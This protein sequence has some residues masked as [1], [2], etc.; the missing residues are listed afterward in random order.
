MLLSS[1]DL[2]TILTTFALALALTPIVRVAARRWG[3]VAQPKADRWHKKPTAML[4]GVAIFAPVVLGYF[5]LVPHTTQSVVVVTASAFMFALGLI[6]DLYHIKPYQKLIGQVMGAALVI[7]YGLSLPWTESVLVNLMLTIFWL[8]GITNAINLLDNMDGL[9][10]GIAAIASSFL[11]FNFLANGQPNEALVLAVLAAALL[12]FL[13]YNSNPAS[14]FMGDCGS[15]FVGFFLASA[16]LLSASGTTGR[17]RSLLPVLAVPIL[18]LFIPIFDTTLVTILR[19]LA[20]RAAS[21]GGRDHTSHRLV[22]LGMSERRAVWMLYGFAGL[23][24][25]LAL[26]VREMEVDVSLAVLLGFVVLLT[27]LGVYLAGVKV[28]DEEEIAAARERPLF[29]FLVD[30]SYKRR[31]FEVLLDVVLFILAYYSA[32]ALLFGSWSEGRDWQLFLRTLP[33]IV[34]VKLAMF[35]V[36]GVYRGIWRYTSVNDLIVF[37]K[38]VFLG[39]VASVL[40]ILFTSRFDGFS[41]TVFAVDGMLL[42][43]MVAG[44][45]FAFRLL[46]NLLP[47]SPASNGR[48]V[49]IYGA[50]DAGELLLRELRNNPDLRYTPVGFIDDDLSKKDKVIH[51]LRVFAGNGGLQG[52]CVQQG[53]EEVLISSSRFSEERT[54]EIL[55]HCEEARV[56]VKRMRIHIEQLSSD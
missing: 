29:A 44:S 53:V 21:Q 2:V 35:L 1:H 32:Y 40:A 12:G 48:R 15:L 23:S 16:S 50:G 31:I 11:A 54:K 14:I 22:A 8:I 19:K 13:V 6:D 27:L 55:R 49:L 47:T 51:G 52:I 17:S 41:R 39:T 3:Y 56:T 38:A 30:L 43:I 9:A 26:V 37:A 7:S 10:A 33:V 18:I 20:G 28:Y 4:G 5:A 24:G 46:R 42:L 36:T 45:R 34:V 25:L